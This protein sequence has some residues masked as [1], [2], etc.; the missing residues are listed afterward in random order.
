MI[1]TYV[2]GLGVFMVFMLG[3]ILLLWLL[4]CFFGLLIELYVFSLIVLFL[5]F[6]IFI[7]LLWL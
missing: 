3:G 5:A 1:V 4:L 6:M 2:A 7:V